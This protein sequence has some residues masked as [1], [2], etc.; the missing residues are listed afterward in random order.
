LKHKFDKLSDESLLEALTE[1]Y[2]KYRNNLVVSW[3][4]EQYSEAR[5]ALSAIVEELS[6]RKLPHLNIYE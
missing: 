3:N 5:L 1:Y 2:E 4:D 6:R